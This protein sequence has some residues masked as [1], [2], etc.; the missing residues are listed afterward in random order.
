[1]SSKINLS[2]FTKPWRTASV[3]ELAAIAK[4]LGFNGIEFPLREGY[5]VEPQNA[6]KDLPKLVQTLTSHGIAV[7]SVASDTSEA[8]FAGCA[9]AGIP[10]IRVMYWHNLNQNYMD[11]IA[12][13]R[14]EIEGFLPLCEKYGV[15]VGVQQHCGP[16]IS[17][18]MELRYLVEPYDP[19]WVGG[20]W[21]AA[22]SGLAGEEPEQ[23]IDMIWDHM[24][25][26]NF[27]SAMYRRK[28]G[29]E[30]IRAAYEA[31][32]TTG[33]QGICSWPRALARM[34]QRGFSGTICMP[35]EYS[36]EPNE[37]IYAAIDNADIRKLIESA[38]GKNALNG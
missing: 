26:V 17:S 31:F 23:A 8:V 9:E 15:T 36:D 11:T 5:Q 14:R 37:E 22:H 29:P 13:I 10:L 2:V 21:D 20:I 30:A 25:G 32:F 34:A 38:F 19:K 18:T 12:A 7:T 28:N 16:S 27:K 6:E 3:D 1:M 24:V 33:S 35:A 4:R